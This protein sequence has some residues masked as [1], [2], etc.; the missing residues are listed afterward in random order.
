MGKKFTKSF[1]QATSAV[2]FNKK[3]KWKEFGRKRLWLD[4]GNI[5]PF[6]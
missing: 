1:V 2:D 5:L 6:A 3:S 4:R